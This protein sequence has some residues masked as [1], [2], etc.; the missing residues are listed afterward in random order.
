MSEE[1]VVTPL[2]A[3]MSFSY[4]CYRVKGI[5][6]IDWVG[7]SANT[8][9]AVEIGIGVY[10]AWQAANI[11]LEHAVAVYDSA[12]RIIAYIGRHKDM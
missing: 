12:D 3:P 11:A 10:I 4:N 1:P 6:K 2:P 9:N 8:A 7:G 5:S